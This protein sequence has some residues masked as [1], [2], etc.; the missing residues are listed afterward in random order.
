V[1]TSPGPGEPGGGVEHT[2]TSHRAAATKRYGVKV[3]WPYLLTEAGFVAY[4]IAWIALFAANGLVWCAL[5]AAYMT[6]CVLALAFF[7]GDHVGRVCFVVDPSRLR[8]LA[9]A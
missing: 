3:H 6:A 2:A 4:Q 8:L 9:R 7:Y 1:T 5:G